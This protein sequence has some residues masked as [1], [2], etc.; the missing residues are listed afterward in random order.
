M[1]KAPLEKAFV[2]SF[3]AA[4]RARGHRFVVKTHGGPMQ[5]SGI[6]DVL[7]LA[8]GRLVGLEVKRPKVGRLTPLQQRCLAHINADGGYGVVV[9]SAEEAL[10]AMEAAARGETAAPAQLPG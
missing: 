5:A 4:L 9:H 10:A 3:L 6:P 8:G 1:T 7:A 2:S